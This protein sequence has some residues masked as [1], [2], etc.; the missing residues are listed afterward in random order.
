[1]LSQRGVSV[2]ARTVRRRLL[3]VGHVRS[4]RPLKKQKLTKLM[5]DKRHNS[6]KKFQIWT[7]ED[8]E[9]QVINLNY[10]LISKSGLLGVGYV[11]FPAKRV[12]YQVNAYCEQTW[13]QGHNMQGQG[14]GQGLDLQGQGQGQG[15]GIRGKGQ[16]Q[17]LDLQAKAKDLTF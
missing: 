9:R 2:S 17:G 11:G 4:R 12:Y 1:M 5:K 6:A 8:L 15:L 7:V 14:Q 10:F 13:S 3:T 16:S